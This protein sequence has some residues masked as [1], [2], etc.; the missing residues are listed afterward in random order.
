MTTQERDYARLQ[1]RIDREQKR[2]AGAVTSIKNMIN[3]SRQSAE[4]FF[5]VAGESGCRDVLFSGSAIASANENH[6]ISNL[7]PQESL[8]V[9]QV[10]GTLAAGGE[11]PPETPL[12]LVL[13]GQLIALG[14]QLSLLEGAPHSVDS[15]FDLQPQS[16]GSILVADFPQVEGGDELEVM[17]ES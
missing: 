15:A 4:G 7:T 6:L 12:K 11:V 16:D 13:L 8:G 10:I 2:F 3:S 14:H 9:F 17:P 1:D 5:S